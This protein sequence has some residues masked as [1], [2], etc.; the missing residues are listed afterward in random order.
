MQVPIN[1][2]RH[3]DILIFRRRG[4]VAAALS[5]IIQRIKEPKWD[6]WG[7]HMCPVVAP[8]TYLDATFP[9]LKLSKISDALAAGRE[10]RCYRLLNREPEQALTDHFISD[11]LGKPYDCLIYL[12]TALAKLLRP[13]I[14]VPRIINRFYDCWETAYDALDYWG[15]DMD[16]SE[17]EY[18]FITDFLRAVGERRK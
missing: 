4:I 11:H 13:W 12:W 18:P 10:I 9:R 7:W 5:W 6:R 16:A 3:G 2:A 8:D 1:E 14:P 15:F 17:W